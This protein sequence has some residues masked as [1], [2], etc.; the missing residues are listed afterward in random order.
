MTT[1]VHLRGAAPGGALGLACFTADHLE[2][3]YL[4]RIWDPAGRDMVWIMLNPSLADERTD[5]ATI[6]R[7]ARY[8]RREGC[9]SITVVNLFPVIST[10][11]RFLLTTGAVLN[12]AAAPWWHDVNLRI[13]LDAARGRQITLPDPAVLAAQ[14]RPLVMCGWGANGGNGRLAWAAVEAVRLLKADGITWHALGY[15]ANR[16]PSHPLRLRAGA[17]LLAARR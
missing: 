6:R 16:Q 14:P 2:R 17:P 9:G 3:W 5:D 4:R 8:A 15:T 7:C 10:S 13:I 11:P 12:G 1:F